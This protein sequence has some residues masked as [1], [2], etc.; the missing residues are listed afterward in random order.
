MK[1]KH[2]LA[3]G[4]YEAIMHLFV[5]LWN[6]YD[7][8]D[9]DNWLKERF[10][11]KLACLDKAYYEA[12]RKYV[13]ERQTC[14]FVFLGVEYALGSYKKSLPPS[15]TLDEE[16]QLITRV[17]SRANNHPLPSSLF[18]PGTAFVK[19]DGGYTNTCYVCKKVGTAGADM[20][21][22]HKQ[23]LLS[24][25][26]AKVTGKPGDQPYYSSTFN[27]IPISVQI[28]RDA[29]QSPPPSDRKL[30]LITAAGAGF[31]G[32]V[33]KCVQSSALTIC[34]DYG[35]VSLA[36]SS[37]TGR[38]FDNAKSVDWKGSAKVAKGIVLFYAVE[39]RFS[40]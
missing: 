23:H 38:F 4:H 39:A 37:D 5:A 16:N 21:V 18:V 24:G 40:S 34:A 12:C 20:D 32:G 35:N 26:V 15:L 14:A 31:D 2:F 22:Y 11:F 36:A 6:P 29:T 7:F 19:R 8:E 27:G 33:K 9:S 10:S 30:C 25:M 3:A 17:Q 28:C 1:A 13:L